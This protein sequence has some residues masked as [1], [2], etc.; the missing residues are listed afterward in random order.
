MERVSCGSPRAVQDRRRLS[1]KPKDNSVGPWAKDKL[2]SLQRGLDYYTTR[3]K[4]QPY[5]QQVYVDAFAGPG[6]STVR[7]KPREEAGEHFMTD[8]FAALDE[9]DPVEEE[10]EYLK[11]SPRVALDI[12]NP[13]DRYIFIEKDVKR[14]AELEALKAEYEGKRH[15]EVIAGDANEILLKV[16]PDI[17]KRSHRVFAFLDPFGL[18]MPWSTIKALA[19]TG[20]TEVMINFP[21]GM[22]IRRMMP[23]SG[24]MPRGWEIS[25]TAFFGSPDWKRYAYEEVEDLMGRTVRKF[26]DS[27][28]R[29]LEWYR[30]RLRQAF[31]HVSQAQ[32]ITNT[33]GGRLYYLV[34]AG[35]HPAGLAGAD[36]I[37]TGKHKGLKA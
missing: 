35:P 2:E 1:K 11:G 12:P 16:I 7:T 36:H 29:L 27:E 5:W 37:L 32:L 17:K 4:K 6:L 3:L 30:G 10:V 8:M 24:E 14:L 25:L 20:A 15:I 28:E 19:K 21:M 18:H 23:T 33:R 13:F 22:A 26:A 34:W 9:S 31:G